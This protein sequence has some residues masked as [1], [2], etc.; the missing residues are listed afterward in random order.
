VYK[1]GWFMNLK[2]TYII[3]ACVL[4]LFS[5]NSEAAKKRG[6]KGVFGGGSLSLGLGI[7][8]ATAE[9]T[10]INDII[11]NAKA[12][13]QATTS[14]LSSATE[15]SLQATFTFA[16][17][18]VA[19]QLRPTLFNESSSGSGTAGSYNYSLS[20]F[21]IFPL[22]RLIP[23]SNDLIDFYLQ[24]GLGYGRL[25]GDITNGPSKISFAGSN[26]G[27]QAGLGA[28]FCFLPDH[29]FGVEGN[30]KYLPIQRNITSSASGGLSNNIT[31]ATVDQ[32]LE[33][34]GSDMAT[35]FSGISGTVSY[36]YNF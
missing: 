36:T 28:N 31:Q 34:N 33:V 26:F 17:G 11:K 19:I 21:T 9:Q 13:N 6:G 8:F 27:V 3:L 30:Y 10:G 14:E 5:V 29:C 20:G 35:G 1:K 22:V 23:L 7:G 24:A 25:G 18:L 15:Y 32:E 12:A 16:N 4:F 2:N